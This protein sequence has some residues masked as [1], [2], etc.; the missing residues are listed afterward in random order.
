MAKE[1][2][3]AICCY[4]GAVLRP[5]YSWQDTEKMFFNTTDGGYIRL[6]L[7]AAGKALA[8][9]LSVHQIGFGRM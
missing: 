1:R 8:E 7:L 3:I 6:N 4:D 2:L 5:W 9:D